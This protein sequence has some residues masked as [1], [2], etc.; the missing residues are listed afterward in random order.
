MFCFDT[1]KQSLQSCC[2]GWETE[3]ERPGLSGLQVHDNDSRNMWRFWT[4]HLSI[5]LK[6]ELSGRFLCITTI[7]T[8]Q[9]SHCCFVFQAKH[10]ICDSVGGFRRRRTMIDKRLRCRR[11]SHVE[12]ILFST[13]L[14]FFFPWQMLFPKTWCI[15]LTSLHESG[16]S[17][18]AGK[19]LPTLSALIWHASL[20]IGFGNV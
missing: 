5:G 4:F 6:A 16:V 12:L 15:L 2:W 17:G 11:M 9:L 13:K 19:F 18:A 8:L 10:N 7:Q 20:E 3:D 1:F 14:L